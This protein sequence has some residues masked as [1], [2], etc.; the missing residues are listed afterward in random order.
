MDTKKEPQKP[1]VLKI[2][3]KLKSISKKDV[4]EPYMDVVKMELLKEMMNKDQIVVELQDV[5]I[6]YTDVVPMV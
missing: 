3:N 1:L 5:P 6:P 4:T 2:M